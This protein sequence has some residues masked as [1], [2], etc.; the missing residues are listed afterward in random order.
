MRNFIHIHIAKNAGTSVVRS[1]CGSYVDGHSSAYHTMT[2][3]P[4]KWEDSFTFAFIRNPWDRLVSAYEFAR[5]EVSY[6]HNNRSKKPAWHHPDHARVKTM[7]FNDF[8]RDFSLNQKHY[9]HPSFR[10]Q[11]SCFCDSSQ[12]NLLDFIGKFE[13]LE[14]DFA[15]IC[16]VLGKPNIS[17]KEHDDYRK[18]YSDSLI[19]DVRKIYEID[20]GIMN[21]EFE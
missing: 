17:S 10:P 21:Y 8:V 5:M 3:D 1:L 11:W 6:W 18:Y 9:T 19:E 7:S 16:G 15:Y 4:K 13:H 12:R 14:R 2:R 20:I